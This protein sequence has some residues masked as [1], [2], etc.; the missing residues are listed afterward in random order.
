MLDE[1]K[2]RLAAAG[3]AAAGGTRPGPGL[4]RRDLGTTAPPR[5]TILLRGWRVG[6]IIRQFRFQVAPAE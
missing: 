2:G 1:E 6:S 4:M 3:H 5:I